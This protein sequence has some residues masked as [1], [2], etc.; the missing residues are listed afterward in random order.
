MYK[1]YKQSPLPA[2]L[3]RRFFVQLALYCRM[4]VRFI[5]T[6]NSIECSWLSSVVARHPRFDW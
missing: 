5:T 4:N 6:V 3:E 1:Q 2:P